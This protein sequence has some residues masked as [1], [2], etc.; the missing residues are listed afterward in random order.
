MSV[1]NGHSLPFSLIFFYLLILLS[2]G[3][4]DLL[5]NYELFGEKLKNIRKNLG[6]TQKDLA[7]AANVEDKTIRRVENSNGLPR[8]D[9]LELLSPAYKVDLISLLLECR[10]DDYSIFE[11]LK[12]KIESKI[13]NIEQDNLIIEINMLG[14]LLSS[15]KNK[16]YRDLINQLLLFTEASIRYKHD[17]NDL[18]IDKYIESLKVTLPTFELDKYLSFTYSSFEIRILMNIAFVL[19]KFGNREKYLEILEFCIDLCDESDK[20]YPKLCHN[21]AGAYRRNKAYQKSLE[22]SNMGIKSCQKNRTYNGLPI[23]YYGKS[24]AEYY[25]G[26]S[27]HL[28]SFNLSI[29]LCE[30]FG[31]D[32]LRQAIIDNCKEIL[33]INLA[34]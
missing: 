17:D 23:L 28:K 13:D 2:L 20:I 31:Q 9:T 30:T 11:D 26:K 32:N 34:D 15:V 24:L 27:E 7:I 21:L 3:G 5:Y 29:S 22:L 25:L 19:N 12:N 16:Y 6:L 10:L 4:I 18:A 33:D 8:L 14:K 1:I